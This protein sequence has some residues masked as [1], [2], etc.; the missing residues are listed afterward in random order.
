[1]T[2]VTERAALH[3]LLGAG[4]DRLDIAVVDELSDDQSPLPPGST[5]KG[6]FP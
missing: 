2:A 6:V 1:V 4:H 5:Q 3:T